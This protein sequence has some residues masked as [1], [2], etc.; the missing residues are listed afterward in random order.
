MQLFNR[1][2]YASF[3][4][5]IVCCIAPMIR[6]IQDELRRAFDRAIR[7]VLRACMPWLGVL[8][9]A[10]VP[11][12]AK[13]NLALNGTAQCVILTAPGAT[14][15]ETHAAE[16][17]SN[18][19]QQITGARFESRTMAG[20]PTEY[21]ILVGQ[22]LAA[23]NL[24]PGA[25]LNGLGG[26]DYVIETAGHR[27]LLAGGRPRGTLY[28]VYRFLQDQL[29]VRFYTP[30][31]THVP[32]IPDLAI[33][34]IHKHGGPAFEY[35]DPFWFPAFD[36]DWAARNGSN[37]QSARLKE[38]HGGQVTY[39]GFVHTFYQ[40]VPPETWF[41]TH[42]EWFSLVK[43]K[44]VG[45][46]A[47][48]CTSNPELRDFVV[49]RVREWLRE[50]AGVN[51]VSVSQNDHA[52]ACECPQCAAIDARE[53]SHAGS[54]L[55]LVNYVAEKIEPDF[56]HVAVDTLAYQYT[57][58]APA[59]L[60][61]R[62]N[63][64][65]RLC[66]IECN[67]A[68]PLEHP[69]NQSFARDIRDW[70]R[71]TNRLYVWDYTTDFSH[72]LLPF[73]NWYVL[74]PNVRFFHRNGVAGLF[75]QGAY[76]SFSNEMSE[77]RGWVLAQLLW[78]PE[79]DDRKL[80]R[81]F[82]EAYYGVPSARYILQY[83][84]LVRSA[85]RP[86]YVGIGHPDA[87][88]FLR[89][90]VLAQ[91][92]TLWQKAQAAARGDHERTWRIRQAHLPLGY[93]WLSQW[94]GLRREC[95][96]TGKKW[97]I[98][99]S[100]KAY[101]EKWLATVNEPG[102]AGWSPMSRMRESGQTPTEFA[103]QMSS[104]PPESLYESPKRLKPARPTHDFLEPKGRPLFSVQDDRAIIFREPDC[105]GPVA[106]GLA[107]DGVAIRMSAGTDNARGAMEIYGANLPKSI[108]PGCYQLY[109]VA[110]VQTAGGAKPDAPAFAA[111]VFDHLSGKYVAERTV[112][113][114]ES[115]SGYR[116]YL[117]GTIK[118]HPYVRLWMGHAHDDSVEAVWLDRIF[119]IPEKE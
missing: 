52:G 99:P 93:M 23:A 78:N 51:I 41:K 47:Q 89:F 55:E 118:I 83:F 48:L 69:S 15:A 80:V 22:G 3:G 117:V 18:F 38:Q 96:A 2:L 14:P 11:A 77:L 94:V 35:R 92:E 30:W 62:P 42:P 63:V 27:L 54:L 58:K 4:K 64:I 102:P 60:R 91:A 40:L 32:K 39:K 110:R 7:Q 103:A 76:Q 31:F 79:Q 8:V 26:E 81:E 72:Y 90:P 28:A 34:E 25:E 13:W 21:T 45:E 95:L 104:D 86:F 66:S 98:D 16:E 87:S 9:L 37:S 114:A 106:D 65:I 46:R 108:R 111:R 36:G 84:E 105:A 68:Q 73:P 10:A 88:P 75:E 53:G 70:H 100:R 49:K 1:L 113:V 101:A 12:Y 17:L 5:R 67:F 119:F 107:S 115:A 116:P 19:L 44:R 33:G 74:G 43:G 59:R 29:G 6:R 24:F 50:S 97:P 20:E 61:P 109:Y 56:P 85:A 57:R 71:L 82:V 112:T